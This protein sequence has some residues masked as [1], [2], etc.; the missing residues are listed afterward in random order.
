MLH[1][2]VVTHVMPEGGTVTNLTIPYAVKEDV[3]AIDIER[4]NRRAG[5]K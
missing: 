1:L 5:A 2:F 3:E 4:W